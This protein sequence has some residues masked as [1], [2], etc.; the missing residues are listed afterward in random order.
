V[1]H[2]QLKVQ[3]QQDPISTGVVHIG[4]VTYIGTS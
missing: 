3:E 2:G 4:P 1:A